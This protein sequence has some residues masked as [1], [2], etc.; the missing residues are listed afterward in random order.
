MSKNNDFDDFLKGQK[1]GKNGDNPHCD[2]PHCLGS[3][4]GI[5]FVNKIHGTYGQPWPHGLMCCHGPC[6]D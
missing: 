5:I 3:I 6:S 4:A 2:N 1:G